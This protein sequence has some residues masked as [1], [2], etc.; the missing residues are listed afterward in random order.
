METSCRK[1]IQ[2]NGKKR[3]QNKNPVRLRVSTLKKPVRAFL[4]KLIPGAARSSSA[5]LVGSGARLRVPKARVETRSPLTARRRLSWRSAPPPVSQSARACQKYR[6][7]DGP[8]RVS[9]GSAPAQC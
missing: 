6:M 9:T 4:R 3:R 7:S 5:V 2:T 1:K 8:P